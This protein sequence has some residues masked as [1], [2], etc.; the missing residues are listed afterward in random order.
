MLFVLALVG[1]VFGELPPM[2]CS[3]GDW[4]IDCLSDLTG[5]ADDVIIDVPEDTDCSTPPSCDLVNSKCSAVSNYAPADCASETPVAPAAH[6]P[7]NPNNGNQICAFYDG[8]NRFGTAFT[9]IGYS[10]RSCGGALCA[11]LPNWNS[12]CYC[13][14]VN[15][16]YF[17]GKVDLTGYA[18]PQMTVN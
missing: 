3:N 9:N 7:I 10:S 14:I 13:L 18:N 8:S 6:P 11:W 17:A 5:T 2:T 15:G 16:E 4:K 1:L 12:G